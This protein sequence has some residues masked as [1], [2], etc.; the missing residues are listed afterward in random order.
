MGLA[1][2]TLALGVAL[3]LTRRPW[4]RSIVRSREVVF[5]RAL[6]VDG[7]AAFVGFQGLLIAAF[8]LVFAFLAL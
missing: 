7:V 3:F 5:G 2:A 8:G 6:D 1:L 4:A